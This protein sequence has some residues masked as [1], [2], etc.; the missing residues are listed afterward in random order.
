MNSR[1]KF[2]V[3]DNRDW[4]DDKGTMYYDAERAYDYLTGIPVNC[5]GNFF[6]DDWI[7]EQCTG[8]SDK[9]GNLIYEGDKV[10]ITI[11]G[12]IGPNGG[13]VDSDTQYQGVVVWAKQGFYVKVADNFFYIPEEPE[14]VEIVGNIHQ[15]KGE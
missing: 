5:F 13:Y 12:S 2:R 11:F 7:V 15:N 14:D 4:S 3:I 9:N 10:E 8:F 1:F 6:D